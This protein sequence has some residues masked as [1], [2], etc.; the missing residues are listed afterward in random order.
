MCLSVLNKW[1]N[2]LHK[3]KRTQD[4]SIQLNGAEQNITFALYS[5]TKAIANIT[6]LLDNRTQS[7][8]V[9]FTLTGDTYI[10]IFSVTADRGS[11][12]FVS[13]TDFAGIFTINDTAISSLMFFKSMPGITGLGLN[14][15]RVGA[16][17]DVNMLTNLNYLNLVNLDFYVDGYAIDFANSVQTTSGGAYLRDVTSNGEAVEKQISDILRAKG[18]NTNIN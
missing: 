6:Y 9:Y 5:D 15:V 18:W 17:E 7:K 12:V 10:A 3:R 16:V 8:Q 2:V 11:R 4:L 13:L 14:N 1:W